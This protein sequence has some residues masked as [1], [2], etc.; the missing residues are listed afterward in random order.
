MGGGGPLPQTWSRLTVPPRPQQL[1]AQE[2]GV[3][4]AQGLTCSRGP[5]PHKVQRSPSE[6][7]APPTGPVVMQAPLLS[8]PW[9]GCPQP[10]THGSTRPLSGNWGQRCHA[11]HPPKCP[12]RCPSSTRCSQARPTPRPLGG[13][14]WPRAGGSAPRVIWSWCPR[15]PVQPGTQA[16]SAPVGALCLG[17]R[18][19]LTFG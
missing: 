13:A 14:L 11:G 12:C 16:P 8:S 15:L 19:G 10:G 17:P 5:A 9:R 3:A 4:W 18:L 7:R 2:S 1:S 6:R